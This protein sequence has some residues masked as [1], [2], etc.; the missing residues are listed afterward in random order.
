[1]LGSERQAHGVRPSSNTTLNRVDRCEEAE[2]AAAVGSRRAVAAEARAAEA[3]KRAKDLAW[4][5]QTSDVCNDF[6]QNPCPSVAPSMYFGGGM[7]KC[8]I[9]GLMSCVALLVVPSICIAM[10]GCEV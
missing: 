5:V 4:Q 7:L 8:I 9:A 10:A 2:L 6:R 3:E 1:M